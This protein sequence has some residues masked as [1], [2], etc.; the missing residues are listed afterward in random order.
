M[1]EG[2]QLETPIKCVEESSRLCSRSEVTLLESENRY[3]LLLASVTDYIYTVNL[4]DGQT[5]ST[6]HG[7]GCER[8]TG[9]TSADYAADPY[10]WLRMVH[11]EDRDAVVGQ[12]AG[13]IAGDTTP[14]EHRIIHKDG[15][16]R[17]VKNT[18]VLQL[19]DKGR[20]IEYDGLIT[21]ITGR[22]LA[23]ERI[24]KLNRARSI[25][26]GIHRAIVH[27]SDRRELMD[28][29]C[30][31]AVVKGGFKLAWIGM[32]APDGSVQP[33]AEAGATGY[34]DGIRVTVRDEPEGRGPIGT[35]IR[36]GH[37][38]AID[39]IDHNAL[40]APWQ[41]RAQQF[42][43]RYVAAFPV[44]IKGRITGSFQV[45]APRARFFDETELNLLTQ[46]S[47]DISFA[48]TAIEVNAERKIAEDALRKAVSDL[49]QSQEELKA[50][51]MLLIN[52]EKMESVG[53]L[54]AGVAHE[55][56]NPLAILM[57]SLDY[58]SH[59]VS[60]Q[61]GTVPGVLNDMRDAIWR[62]DTIIRGLL[63]FS[64][65]E[66]L[67][68]QPDDLNSIIEKASLLVK[69]SRNLN[70]IRFVKNLDPGLPA[71]ALD[72]NK[73]VQVF[74]NLFTNSMDAMPDG[75]TLAVRTW[76]KK[77][78]VIGAEAPGSGTG[79]RFRADDPVV[80]VELEDSG[81]GIPPDK[82]SRI[83]DPFFTTKPPGQGTGLGLPVT[84]KIIDLHRGTLEITNR[85]Q[86][87]VLCVMQFRPMNRDKP[88]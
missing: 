42:G 33:V 69:H 83:F 79:E 7:E 30:R 21:D 11:E 77:I 73:M 29:I 52:A 15:S 55:V 80:V 27:V 81:S 35:A 37:P 65:P 36:E 18:L 22:K 28:E 43:L 57:M 72:R 67:E 6:F 87:G 9:Y 13:C 38:V 78:S 46:V 31:V 14:L 86:G 64:A 70:H 41:H 26:A 16:L 25:I 49:Q 2:R 45:Y 54:A 39:D 51:Q 62:A 20:V 74:V 32:V 84:K 19:D 5:I 50:S 1:I 85:E 10:L 68:L 48:L 63:D 71:V 24:T 23:E 66:Q 59:T 8:V 3:R 17:W 88:L 61:D 47:E 34:V 76:V 53:R 44:R 75:G 40:M 58:L 4:R 56:K 82:L 60:G 12:L